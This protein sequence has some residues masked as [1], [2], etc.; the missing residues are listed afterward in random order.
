MEKNKKCFT[1]K[2]CRFSYLYERDRCRT[3]WECVANPPVWTGNY[4]DC[5][6][7]DPKYPACRFF[8]MSEKAMGEMEKS[9]NPLLHL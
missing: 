4:F 6:E 5:P 8:E 3:H 9:E 1:C 7:I 2:E